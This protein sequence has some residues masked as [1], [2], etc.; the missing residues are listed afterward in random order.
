MKYLGLSEIRG[1]MIDADVEPREAQKSQDS[2]SLT[3]SAARGRISTPIH[4]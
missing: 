2:Q 4:T 3:V 1:G